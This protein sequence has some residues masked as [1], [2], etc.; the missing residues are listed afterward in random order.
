MTVLAIQGG[1]ADKNPHQRKKAPPPSQVLQSHQV[2]VSHRLR[3]L[4]DMAAVLIHISLSPRASCPEISMIPNI[5][6]H[7]VLLV[8]D[9]SG[10]EGKT[11]TGILGQP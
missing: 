1:V 4:E 7:R 2:L 9:N 11:H 6:G 8:E 3:G 10:P 5:A